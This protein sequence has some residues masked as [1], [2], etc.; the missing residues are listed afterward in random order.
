MGGLT[1]MLTVVLTAGHLINELRPGLLSLLSGEAAPRFS[2]PRDLWLL[3]H[4]RGGAVPSYRPLDL[5][6]HTDS[7]LI[8]L[9]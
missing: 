3:L 8:Q 2:F 5:Q 6:V 7:V 9:L 1:K 4:G